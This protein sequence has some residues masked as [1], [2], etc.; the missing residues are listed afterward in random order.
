MW[1]G[2]S[3]ATTLELYFCNRFKI[4]NSKGK[5]GKE[6]WFSITYIKFYSEYDRGTA[7]RMK[8]LIELVDHIPSRCFLH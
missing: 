8:V 6:I 3:F 5:C 1:M 7:V 2:N 4:I